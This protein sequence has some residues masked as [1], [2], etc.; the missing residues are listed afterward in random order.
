MDGGVSPTS[1]V[2]GIS[3]SG[4]SRRNLS[5]AV[6][7]ANEPIP[8][9]S[10]K[11]TI[12]PTAIASRLGTAWRCDRRADEDEPEQQDRKAKRNQKRDQHGRPPRAARFA[13]LP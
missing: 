3:R 5:H 9:V 2:C 8:S 4:T 11:L 13:P 1:M 6:V 7:G 12:A 10:K